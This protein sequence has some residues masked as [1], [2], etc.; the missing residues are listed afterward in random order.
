MFQF[1]SIFYPQDET[2][3]FVFLFYFYRQLKWRKIHWHSLPRLVFTTHFFFY[4]FSLCSKE[5]KD[6][7][8]ENKVWYKY[9][10]DNSS[11]YFQRRYLFDA[12]SSQKIIFFFL[13][14]YFSIIYTI[15]IILFYIISFFFS[16]FI[17]SSFFLIDSAFFFY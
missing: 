12:F 5:K 3:S 2:F 10:C 1:R 13:F 17:F 14:F 7:S 4:L 16:C 8:Q 15:I 9:R 6:K 11:Q